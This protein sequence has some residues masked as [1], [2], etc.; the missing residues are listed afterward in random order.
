MPGLDPGIQVAFWCDVLDP[1][2]TPGLDPAIQAAPLRV[3]VAWMPGSSP[4]M[5]NNKNHSAQ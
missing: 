3:L 2:I 1:Q 5:T 4:G